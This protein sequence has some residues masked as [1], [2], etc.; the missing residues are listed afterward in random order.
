MANKR[1]LSVI[2]RN[3]VS[4]IAMHIDD[5]CSGV[6]SKEDERKLY[7]HVR[8]IADSIVARCYRSNKWETD[9]IGCV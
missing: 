3:I 2:A 4:K 9:E 7:E 8:Q 5:E 1:Q 6:L